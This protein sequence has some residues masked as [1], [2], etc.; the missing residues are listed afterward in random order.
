MSIL[1]GV[2]SHHRLF[3]PYGVL[4]VAKARLLGRPLQVAVTS[5][6]ITHPVFLRLRTTDVSLFEEIILNSEY[7]IELSR[8][9]RTIVD[10]GANIGLTSVFFANTFPQARIIAIEPER[11]N[12]E[13]LK[14]N[15]ARYSNILPVQGALWRENTVLSLSDP[16]KGHWGY[17]TREK[18]ADDGAEGSVP[19]LTVDRLMKLYGL[20]CIDILKID[21]E[22]AEKEVFET[23]ASWIDKVGVI[24]VELHDRSKDGCSRSV[25]AAVQDFE[26]EWCKGETTFF[27]RRDYAPR[28]PQ[29][30]PTSTNSTHALSAEKGRKHRTRIRSVMS[31]S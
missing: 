23:S 11:S 31:S 17:Q 24:I 6:R 30:A 21:I 14:R 27:V 15:A 13:M 12:F 10:A 28:G 25:H 20:D 1:E 4:L 7:F 8:P 5:D 26:L 16:G 9:P 18:R 2:R 22:G 29:Q 3:G 19:G